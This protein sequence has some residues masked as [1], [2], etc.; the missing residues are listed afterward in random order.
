[1]GGGGGLGTVWHHDHDYLHYLLR[2]LTKY[3]GEALESYIKPVEPRCYNDLLEREPSSFRYKSL[4]EETLGLF[5]TNFLPCWWMRDLPREPLT[6]I[7]P[8]WS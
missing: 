6:L 1:M 8:P 5:M 7:S 2:P 3:K 4:E